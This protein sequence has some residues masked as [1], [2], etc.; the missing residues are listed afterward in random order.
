MIAWERPRRIFQFS[1]KKPFPKPGNYSNFFLARPAPPCYLLCMTPLE[2]ELTDALAAS[3]Q[4][5]AELRQEIDLLKQKINALVRRIFGAKSEQLEPR[6]AG[7]A[8]DRNGRPGPAAG[9][10]RRL[11]RGLRR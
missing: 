9:K 2:T 11:P 6:A 3:Q 1:I 4:Q 7:A 5:N 8:P 10:I